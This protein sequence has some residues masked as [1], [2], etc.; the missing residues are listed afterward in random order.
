M[1]YETDIRDLLRTATRIA[2]DELGTD[3]ITVVLAVFDRLCLERV[4]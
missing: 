3:D 4:P 2:R 1:D